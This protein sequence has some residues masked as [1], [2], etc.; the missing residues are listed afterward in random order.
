MINHVTGSSDVVRV[1]YGSESDID[2]YFELLANDSYTLFFGDAPL[3]NYRQ[4][5]NSR[6]QDTQGWNLI[7]KV[8]EIYTR[9]GIPALIGGM[10]CRY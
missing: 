6:G 7:A 9:C 3:G 10:R 5:R 4:T 2:Q 8:C 1:N